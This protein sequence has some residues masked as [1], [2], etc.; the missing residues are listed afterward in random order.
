VI[1]DKGEKLKR[2]ME[3]KGLIRKE[4]GKEKTFRNVKNE[5]MIELFIFFLS[6]IV[7]YFS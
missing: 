1:G 2:K 3:V 4:E 5:Y 6:L 7:H